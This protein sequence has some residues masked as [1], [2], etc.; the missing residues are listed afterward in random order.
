MTGPV[1]ITPRVRLREAASML[2]V[3]VWSLR[4]WAKRGMV[5]YYIVGQGNY[6]E[7][8]PRDIAAFDLSFRRPRHEPPLE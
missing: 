5:T 1:P 2:G 4:R 6:M 3:S 8:D 7:F